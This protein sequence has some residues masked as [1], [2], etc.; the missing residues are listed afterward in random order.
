MGNDFEN[1]DKRGIH[2][3]REFLSDDLIYNRFD[4]IHKRNYEENEYLFQ[5]ERYIVQSTIENGNL[6]LNLWGKILPQELFENIIDDFFYKRADVV[7][8]EVQWAG[9]NYENQLRK[10]EHFAVLI[11]QENPSIL[12]RL[13]AKEKYNI[14]RKKRNLLADKNG[15][16]I[17]VNNKIEME[18][19]VRFYFK[20][21]KRTHN[22][23]YNMSPEEYLNKYYV[24]DMLAYINDEEILSVLFF[25]KTNDVAYL[26]NF[27]YNLEKSKWSPGY[28]IYVEWLC[29]CENN[30]VKTV[31]LAGGDYAYK[32]KF[33][34]VCLEGYTGKFY[35]KEIF[36]NI[37]AYLNK[38]SIKKLA[39]YGFG[40][41]GHD[42]IQI[43]NFLQSDVAYIIDSNA[44]KYN[45]L[46]PV[47]KP[48]SALLGVDFIVVTLKE[49]NKFVEEDLN[50]Q[51]FAYWFELVN[52][53][54]LKYEEDNRD[55]I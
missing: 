36:E 43:K 25:N 35:R 32:R 39:I 44:E 47:I 51:N 37:N 13:N 54:I 17:Y 4:L 12:A 18:E 15:R 19:Y 46:I 20:E 55:E 28:L 53:A 1:A 40:E 7:S 6:K 27:S 23:D 10:K 33:N 50:G 45:A 42:F 31:F 8:V 5:G 9:N 34:S 52:L 24:T 3:I 21:K 49:K 38:N 30:N 26:E 48:D 29:W 2:M 14:R 41:V 22:K 16:L 11:G